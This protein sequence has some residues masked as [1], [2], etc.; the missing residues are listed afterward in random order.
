MTDLTASELR[1]RLKEIDEKMSS[2]QSQVALL[3]E[4]RALVMEQL[5]AVKYEVLNLPAEVTMEIFLH[6]VDSPQLGRKSRSFPGYR[7][8]SPLLVASV[9][10]EWRHIALNTSDLW[11]TLRL[12][13]AG[14]RDAENLV[15]CW[16]SRTGDLPL[17]FKIT[18]EHTHSTVF[19]IL[20]RHSSQWNTLSLSSWP[21]VLPERVHGQL[22]RLE[23]LSIEFS[24]PKQNF[25]VTAFSVA[26]NLRNLT[27]AHGSPERILLPWLQL[28]HLEFMGSFGQCVSILRHALNVQVLTISTMYGSAPEVPRTP[29]ILPSLHTLIFHWDPVCELLD[30]L[31]LPSLETLQLTG[32]AWNVAD[33]C[34]PFL[35]RSRCVVR[36]LT[37]NLMEMPKTLWWMQALP[38]VRHITI[39]DAQ[40]ADEFTSLFETL[41]GDTCPALAAHSRKH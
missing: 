11:T 38:H 5:A 24:D 9:C 40:S 4:Q 20:A 31:T 32:F 18:G 16:L 10:K 22:P 1:V 25:P 41:M 28:T 6:F 37:T 34:V 3:A 35:A 36:T 13:P 8:H 19:F 30:Y 26:P 17:D 27:I 15:D 21:S 2:L 12:E 7:G 14:V 39:N 33:Y 29:V 23:T